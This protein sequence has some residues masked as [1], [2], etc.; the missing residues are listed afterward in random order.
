MSMIGHMLAIGQA[1]AEAL[2]DAD[3]GYLKARFDGALVLDKAWHAVGWLL[4]RCGA[5]D[6]PVLE[7][8]VSIGDDFG[9]G[10]L[11]YFPPEQTERLSHEMDTITTGTLTDRCDLQ[12]LS[13]EGIYP[14]VWDRVAEADSNRAW[15]V[16][17]CQ[18]VIALYR[19]ASEHGLGI[20]VW[21]V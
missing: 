14:N 15:I 4:V 2:T 7:G 9:Y 8:N 21:I 6:D 16:D 12:A 19:S 10:P 20:A 5:S 3:Y 13:A 11:I 1:D 17:G 18:K